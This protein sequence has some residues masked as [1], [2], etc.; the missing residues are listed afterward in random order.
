MKQPW[1]CQAV[2]DSC[3]PLQLQSAKIHHL[4]WWPLP[5]SESEDAST[6]QGSIPPALLTMSTSTERAAHAG[7]G[8]QKLLFWFP[9]Q[10]WW[11]LR[12]IRIEQTLWNSSTELGEFFH[13]HVFDSFVV[14]KLLAS[15]QSSRTS[16]TLC[17]NVVERLQ[18]NFFFYSLC[19][20]S[21]RT[22]RKKEILKVDLF[23]KLFIHQVQNG[24]CRDLAP[25][26][27]YNLVIF[28][29]TINLYWFNISSFIEIVC[30][31]FYYYYFK[32]MHLPVS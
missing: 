23:L 22:L 29:M 6:P 3:V 13:G 20:C 9:R 17:W 24:V 18:Y 11:L 19:H 25:N 4:P 27:Y 26:L 1:A 8:Q 30:I 5:N 2:V 16:K 21:F 12:T 15:V 28:L 10:S 32:K 14:H 31:S 7:W